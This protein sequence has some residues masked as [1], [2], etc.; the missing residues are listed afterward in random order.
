MKK[1]IGY[2]GFDKDLKCLQHQYETD[3]EY[4]LDDEPSLCNTGFHFCENP[5][6]V[7]NFYPLQNGNR[8]ATV[9]ALGKTKDDG[10]K[11]VTNHIKIGL[12]LDLKSLVNAAVS[13]IFEKAS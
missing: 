3:K 12:E 1:I 5:L 6:N 9:E 11:S 10:V 2:K 8:F 13:F 7:L 4:K